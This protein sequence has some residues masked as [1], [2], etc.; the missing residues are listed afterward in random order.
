MAPL[1]RLLTLS[2]LEAASS[3]ELER[4]A[5]RILREEDVNDVAIYD[6]YNQCAAIRHE[7]N[8]ED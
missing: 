6:V 1:R 2:I 4:G 5:W 7:D 8:V 3:G